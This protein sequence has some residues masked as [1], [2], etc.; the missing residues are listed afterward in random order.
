MPPFTWMADGVPVLLGEY[1]RESALPALGPGFSTLSVIDAKG[2]AARV[3][4]DL[5]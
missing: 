2:R 1:R 3:T 4:V 5:R